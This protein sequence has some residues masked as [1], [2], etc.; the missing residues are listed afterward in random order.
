[1]MANFDLLPHI[2]FF[3][4]SGLLITGLIPIEWIV[5]RNRNRVR[6]PR[7]EISPL[8]KT[9]SECQSDLREKDRIIQCQRETIERLE[10]RVAADIRTIKGQRNFIK[11]KD[12]ILVSKNRLIKELNDDLVESHQHIQNQ[13][14]DIES[15]KAQVEEKDQL[16]WV[17]TGRDSCALETIRFLQLKLDGCFEFLAASAPD[18]TGI[19]R[20]EV[21]YTKILGELSSKL[22]DA[23]KRLVKQTADAQEY[24]ACVEKD[25]PFYIECVKVKDVALRN[26]E[27]MLKTSETKLKYFQ[28]SLKAH[29]DENTKA[30]MTD[31]EAKMDQINDI[32]KRRKAYLKLHIQY[33]SARKAIVAQREDF[34]SQIS[35][36][37]NKL[38]ECR[39][40][41][42][43]VNVKILDTETRLSSV[44]KE[45][46]ELESK[47]KTSTQ[48]A[49]EK[50]L[51]LSF[52]RHALDTA[53][54]QLKALNSE[55]NAHK[56]AKERLE[57]ALNTSQKSA[58]ETHAS[59]Q[60]QRESTNRYAHQLLKT[61]D[62][63]KES[64]AMSITLQ[65]KLDKS[66]AQVSALQAK[67][68]AFDA[69]ISNLQKQYSTIKAT[70]SHLQDK[71]LF[72]EAQ[73]EDLRAVGNASKSQVADL[74]KKLELSTALATKLEASLLS[75]QGALARDSSDL[76]ET[77]RARDEA[78]DLAAAH[79]GALAEAKDEI[80]SL[81]VRVAESEK[82]CE[83]VS[84]LLR[85]ANN[86]RV[87][88]VNKLDSAMRLAYR[89]RGQNG[90]LQMAL[91]EESR[92]REAA[93]GYV[94]VDGVGEGEEEGGSDEE[95]DEYDSEYAD[96]GDD[97]D[98]EEGK[99]EEKAE[100][101][102]EEFENV[103]VIEG[104]EPVDG[105][106]GF[107]FVETE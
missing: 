40:R 27:T 41:V 36:L 61:E 3:V 42:S 102:E 98:E 94:E 86:G 96:D 97:E 50:T 37:N 6:M 15:L 95:D 103:E 9:A 54:S 16:L 69:R 38:Q 104:R 101:N 62:R 10:H 13:Q 29:H 57:S 44:L 85:Q 87:T 77:R 60:A 2:V 39:G 59:L 52:A 71:L 105:E 47:L 1:M 78:Q 14:W 46:E 84:Q 92:A 76:V 72:K 20:L 68:E 82:A 32:M 7:G 80:A 45:N 21:K 25:V 100:E 66:S 34:Q 65:G 18:T 90:R 17:V 33:A 93:E 89:L 5:P 31:C 73:S 106:E 8:P 64:M 22:D 35:A 79:D 56:L 67:H 51:H 12:N 74:E 48:L 49:E 91:G 99:A 28:D 53:I 58:A 83:K 55:C 107:Q 88:A 19:D 23:E 70:N 30:Y 11:I 26:A 4:L 63:Y 24:C 81:K 75:A 43:A